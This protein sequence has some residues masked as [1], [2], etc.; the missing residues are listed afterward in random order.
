MMTASTMRI[1]GQQTPYFRNEPFSTVYRECEE[2]LLRTLNAPQGARA[3]FITGSGT[4]AMEAAVLNFTRVGEPIATINGGTF[5]QRFVDIAKLHGRQVTEWIVDRVQH[6]LRHLGVLHQSDAYAALLINAHETS[7]G[8]L[9]DLRETGAFCRNTTCLHIVDAISAF[10][11][12]EIDMQSQSIDVVILSSHKALGLH[13]GLS[14][15]VMS[16][17]ALGKTNPQ[18]QSYYFSLASMLSDGARG[19]TPF[20][21]A[22]TIMHQLQCRLSE[23]EAQG[24]HKLLS[25]VSA[26]ATHFRLGLLGLP[27]TPYSTSMSNGLTALEVPAHV[28]ARHI[29]DRLS[30]EHQIVVA[31]NGGALAERIFRVGHMGHLSISDMDEVLLALSTILMEQ[32]Q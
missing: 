28:S 29:V 32:T 18:P 11:T 30:T 17:T 14:M 24:M 6:P 22:I 7:I 12:D 9:Y 8:H 23:W 15:L 5:G 1:G 31:P 13:P 4:A 26:L 25:E 21:P 19:Q 3:A 16:P 27:L 20:T 2:R 10:G